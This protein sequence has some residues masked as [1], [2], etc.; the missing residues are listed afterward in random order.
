MSHFSSVLQ[1][2]AAF[3]SEKNVSHH[4]ELPLQFKGESVRLDTRESH[5]TDWDISACKPIMVRKLD[6]Y[7]I[8]VLDFYTVL[9]HVVLFE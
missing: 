8:P 3:A 7:N 9:M 5:L 1:S 4:H 2:A 6:Y